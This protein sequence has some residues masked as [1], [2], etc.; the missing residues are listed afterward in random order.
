MALLLGDSLLRF[1]PLNDKFN[2]VFLPGIDCESLSNLICK[3]EFDQLLQT[4][5]LVIILVGTNDIPLLFPD[6]VAKRVVS[7]ALV[8]KARCRHLKVAVAGILPRPGDHGI[9]SHA[10][11]LCNKEIEA[12]CKDTDNVPLRSYRAFLS[13]NSLVPRH[14]HSDGLH[15]SESGCTLLYRGFLSAIDRHMK[16]R[17]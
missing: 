16:G 17:L 7:V 8:I 13:F 9:Y 15:L 1:L 2:K 5:S 4:V 6:K 10:I 12:I 11:K 14:F 3:G